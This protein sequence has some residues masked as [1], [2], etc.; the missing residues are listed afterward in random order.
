MT[1]NCKE[2]ILD[3]S[4]F[5]YFP[6]CAQLP[7]GLWL[8]HTVH[9]CAI[10]ERLGEPKGPL[11]MLHK[12]ASPSS[13]RR[14][15]DPGKQCFSFVLSWAILYK[16][17]LGRPHGIKLCVALANWGRG[18]KWMIVDQHKDPGEGDGGIKVILNIYLKWVPLGPGKIGNCIKTRRDWMTW[19]NEV[20]SQQRGWWD[21]RAEF[22]KI[23]RGERID[24]KINW[25]IDWLKDW[26]QDQWNGI[27]SRS[28]GLKWRVSWSDG[29]RVLGGSSKYTLKLLRMTGGNWVEKTTMILKKSEGVMRKR[30]Q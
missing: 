26:L 1:D 9:V 24:F 5:L 16:K 4:T 28:K 12:W 13:W 21:Q 18:S 7:N 29:V 22:L 14:H 20:G 17:S 6:H 27:W 10:E 11:N 25:K 15:L 3:K 19:E 8:A 30:C 23:G 2:I